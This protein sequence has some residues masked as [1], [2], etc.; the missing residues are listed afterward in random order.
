VDAAPAA[1]IELSARLVDKNGKII[2]SLL[3]EASQ[4]LDKIE[5]PAAVAAFDDA[6]GRIAKGIVLWTVRAL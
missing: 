2:A 3:F 4:K 6:F 1:E 5:P